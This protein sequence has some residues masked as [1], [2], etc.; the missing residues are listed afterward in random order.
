MVGRLR[1]AERFEIRLQRTFEVLFPDRPGFL[2]VLRLEGVDKRLSVVE[3]PLPAPFKN[4]VD[5]AEALQQFAFVPDHPDQAGDA[6]GVD[7][8]SAE[9]SCDRPV[10]LGKPLSSLREEQSSGSDEFLQLLD[11]RRGDAS[12]RIGRRQALQALSD[13]EDVRRILGC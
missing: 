3:Q 13:G 8:L 4:P 10:L 11:L 7:E 9:A 12:A 5:N 2:L 1:P 6:A